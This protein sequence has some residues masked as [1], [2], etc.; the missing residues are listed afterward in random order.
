M[1]SRRDTFA[2]TSAEGLLAGAIAGLVMTVFMMLWDGLT[3]DGIWTM[4]QLIATIVLGPGAYEAGTH[5]LAGPVLTGFALHEL[6]SAAMGLFFVMLLRL[7]KMN[8]FA[9]G[10]ALVYGLVSGV[11]AEW[12]LIPILSETMAR[13]TEPVQ[14][15]AGHAIFGLALGTA[16]IWMADRAGPSTLRKNEGDHYEEQTN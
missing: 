11:V 9:L 14:L 7:L 15:L 10:G 2:L 13:H 6:T 8:N 1:S 3:G 12:W 4:P 5:F 16:Y